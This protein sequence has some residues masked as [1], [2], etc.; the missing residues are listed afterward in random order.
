MPFTIVCDHECSQVIAV[1]ELE[2]YFVALP[3]C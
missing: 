1:D 2:D 3:K